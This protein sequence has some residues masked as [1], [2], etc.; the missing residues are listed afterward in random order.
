MG[1]IPSWG[2]ARGKHKCF[3]PSLPL[4]LK[5]NLKNIF[6]LRRK[7]WKPGDWLRA[8]YSYIVQW[9]SA[10]AVHYDHSGSLSTLPM[11]GLSPGP[12]DLISLEGD[13]TLICFRSSTGNF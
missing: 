2:H 11:P 10:L 9:S 13:P 1:Q 12:L 8:Y 6:I 3:S 5:I 4:S 7:T